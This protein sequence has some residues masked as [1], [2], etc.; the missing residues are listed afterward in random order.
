M[1][2]IM[3]ANVLLQWINA[4]VV[5]SAPVEHASV[6]SISNLLEQIHE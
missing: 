2:P 6:S 3:F 5:K 4:R 1:P